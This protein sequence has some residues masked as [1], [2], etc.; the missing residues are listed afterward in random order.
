LAEI[1]SGSGSFIAFATEPGSVAS[2]G[3]G[4]NSPFSAALKKHIATPGLSLSD[5]MI[6]VRRQ[7]ED[8]TKGYQTPWDHSSLRGQFYFKSAQVTPLPQAPTAPPPGQDASLEW[9]RVDKSSVAE[10]E[11]F[12]RRHGSSSEADYARSRL[13]ALKDAPQS[14]QCNVAGQWQQTA[15]D[16][17]SSIWILTHIG[18]NRYS[19]QENG[20]GNA[21]GTGLMTGNRIRIDWRTGDWSGIY[22]W[23]IDP[24][25][26]SGEGELVF[27]SG[28]SGTHR[29]VARRLLAATPKQ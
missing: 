17:G 11:T 7:V 20:M 16:V 19:A 22:E 18:D 27:F 6:E 29:S 25:C 10:L 24:S 1:K 26:T 3:S 9:S 21:T 28:G 5:L 4:R 23:S 12:L 8:E 14:Q 15:A 13:A 2:D